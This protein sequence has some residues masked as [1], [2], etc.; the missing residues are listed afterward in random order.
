MASVGT[1]RTSYGSIEVGGSVLASRSSSATCFAGFARGIVAV[2]ALICVVV[3]DSLF[4]LI[5]VF[6][7][8]VSVVILKT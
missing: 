6:S 4:V 2:V 8:S 5:V 3:V 7:L 1:E